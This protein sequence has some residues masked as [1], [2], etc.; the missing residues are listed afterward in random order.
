[1][2]ILN[3]VPMGKLRKKICMVSFVFLIFSPPILPDRSTKKMISEIG[4]K[5]TK[6]GT[7]VNMAI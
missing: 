4:S 3:E 5:C 7:T 1:M 6:S 2:D